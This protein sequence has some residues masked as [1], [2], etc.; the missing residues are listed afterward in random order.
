MQTK[1]P[2]FKNQLRKHWTWMRQNDD[3]ETIYPIM[4]KFIDMDVDLHW[5]ENT[6]TKDVPIVNI[7]SSQQYTGICSC[8]NHHHS[9][10]DTQL[11]CIHCSCTSPIKV[12][13]YKI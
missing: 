2:S 3:Y 8:V 6:E 11:R 7:G 9:L 13:G 4:E 5:H 1:Y 12:G 10:N